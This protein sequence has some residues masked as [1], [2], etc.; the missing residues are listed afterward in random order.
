[1]VNSP[2][3]VLIGT[4]KQICICNTM[5]HYKIL[6]VI[7]IPIQTH[8]INCHYWFSNCAF[9][10][11]LNLLSLTWCLKEKFTYMG[12]ARMMHFVLF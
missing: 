9:S 8:Y 4:T 3:H 2:I 6:A 11:G 5:L 10:L 7:N 12:I 1:M